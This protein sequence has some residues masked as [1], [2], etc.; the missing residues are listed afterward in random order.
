[1]WWYEVWT[2]GAQ[3]VQGDAGEAVSQVKSWQKNGI[4]KP[5]TKTTKTQTTIK[6]NGQLL[7]KFPEALDTK[8]VQVTRSIM[9]WAREA[10]YKQMVI[11][12]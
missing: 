7:L 2:P 3:E 12:N 10:D 8:E 6:E 4:M 11:N 9:F 5:G 1:M